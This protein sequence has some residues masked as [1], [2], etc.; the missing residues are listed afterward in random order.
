M[1]ASFAT[2]SVLAI[3]CPIQ[4]LSVQVLTGGPKQATVLCMPCMQCSFVP[5]R[6]SCF[7]TRRAAFLGNPVNVLCRCCTWNVL[8]CAAAATARGRYR[9]HPGVRRSTVEPVLVLHLF[10]MQSCVSIQRRFVVCLTLCVARF[11]TC[12]FNCIAY[13]LHV[14][15]QML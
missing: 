4:L 5:G 3:I 9:E 1:C 8:Q 7:C 14:L 11:T 15:H 10:V 2:L 13:G 12:Q 6:V